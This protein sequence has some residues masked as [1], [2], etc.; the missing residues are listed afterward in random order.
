MGDSDLSP[1]PFHGRPGEDGEEWV[2]HFENYCAYRL[3]DQS[4]A[5]AL[6]KILL[7]EPAA[8]WVDSLDEAVTSSYS[9]LLEA[10]KTRYMPPAAMKFKSAKEL[11]S[12]RQLDSETVDGYIEAMYKLARQLVSDNK[13]AEELARYA[14]MGGLKPHISAFVVQ[15]E[16]ETLNDVIKAA[17]LAEMTSTEPGQDMASQI[18]KLH[19]KID[20]MSSA[21]SMEPTDN[22]PLSAPGA[23]RVTFNEAGPQASSQSGT[24]SPPPANFYT[25]PP[26][27]PPPVQ[28]YTQPYVQQYIPAYTQQYAQPYMQPDGCQ[29][30]DPYA[31]GYA[32]EYQPPAPRQAYRGNRRGGGVFVTRNSGR[33]GRGAYTPSYQAQG[34]C[35]IPGEVPQTTA[36]QCNKCGRREHPSP[37]QCPAAN[38]ICNICQKM[39]HFAAVCRSAM[40][41][42][43]GPTN[44]G[45]TRRGSY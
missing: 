17:R 21:A 15:R 34:S 19:E 31:Q 43:I 12:R 32:Q 5:L 22:R 1:G 23:R 41:G 16:P 33:G 11:Y 28:T 29:A 39:G 42:R 3:F 30:T 20:R 44:S 18:Q 24:Y 10:F 45:G 14:I 8:T 40:R 2:R 7:V 36:D 6:M 27:L 26:I 37:L 25:P 9:K 4:R 38:K 35:Q 13:Q